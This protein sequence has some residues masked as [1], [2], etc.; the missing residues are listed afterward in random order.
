M[1]SPLTAF[2]RTVRTQARGWN[3]YNIMQRQRTPEELRANYFVS[4]WV[5][6]PDE[7]ASTRW[8]ATDARQRLDSVT[9]ARVLFLAPEDARI[10]A[11]LNDTLSRSFDVE[12]DAAV[13][14]LLVTAPHIHA[15]SFKVL[16][17]TRRFIGYGATFEGGGVTVDNYSVRSNNGQ[18]MFWT[19]P[20]VNAQVNAMLGYDLVVLQYGLNIMQAGV[21]AYNSYGRQVEKMVAYVRQC[22]PGAAVLVLGVSDRSVKGEAGFEPM[23]AVPYMSEC[24]RRAARNTG[25]AFWPTSDAM[26]V[27]GGMERFVASG[28]AGKDYTHINYAG[29]R[30][31]AWALFDALNAALGDATLR[32]EA[33]ARRREMQQGVIDSLHIVRLDRQLFSGVMLED[34]DNTSLQ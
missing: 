5:C 33:E 6:S 17:G 19:N 32:L 3:S 12:G 10:E 8:E 22:F 21:H 30:Q 4:G 18:A 11:T 13:R 2:R 15:L 27:L 16:S 20:S 34:P 1:A 25:A 14:Q 23:D 29:G 28:W 24:Q 31:V 7:G 9:T 26:R